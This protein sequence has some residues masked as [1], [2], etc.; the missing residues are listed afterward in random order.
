MRDVMP[1]YSC[2]QEWFVVAS[3]F[4]VSAATFFFTVVADDHP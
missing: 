4:S 2:S 1:S 3:R